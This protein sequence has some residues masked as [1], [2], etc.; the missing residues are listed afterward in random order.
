MMKVDKYWTKQMK[1]ND[2]I[3][4]KCQCRRDFIAKHRIPVIYNS[5]GSGLA[6]SA[7]LFQLADSHHCFYLGGCNKL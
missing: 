4:T 5:A 2:L 6:A 3:S 1:I 7:G